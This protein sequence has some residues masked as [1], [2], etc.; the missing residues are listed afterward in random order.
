MNQAGL[1]GG[2]SDTNLGGHALR[3]VLVHEFA[4]SYKPYN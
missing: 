4:Y 1:G 3:T 2:L